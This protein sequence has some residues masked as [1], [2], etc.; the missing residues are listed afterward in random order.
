MRVAR[1]HG[2]RIPDD[3]S[4]VGLDDVLLAS[5]T[6]PPLTTVQQPMR[7]MGQLAAQILLDLFHSGKPES[8]VTL[9]GK[10]IVR[11]STA[12]PQSVRR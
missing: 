12:P 10:L 8:H 9:P 7:H 4:I 3:L 2:L 6:D 11:R 5:Y 1:E